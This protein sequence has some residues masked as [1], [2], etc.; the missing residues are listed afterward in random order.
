MFLEFNKYLFVTFVALTFLG[1]PYSIFNLYFTDVTGSAANNGID[2]SVY[3]S[4]VSNGSAIAVPPT[5]TTSLLSPTGS[6]IVTTSLKPLPTQTSV[7]LLEVRCGTSWAAANATCGSLCFTD[8]DCSPGL[9]CYK[10]VVGCVGRSL[11]PRDDSFSNLKSG[12]SNASLI[13]SSGLSSLTI[14]QIDAK[15]PWFWLPTSLTWLFSIICYLM[16]YK[17]CQLY[18]KHRRF[19]FTTSEFRDSVAHR[20][21]LITYIPHIKTSQELIEFVH[22]KD[23]SL[24]IQ[25]A[26]INRNSVR[27]GKLLVEHKD[28][29]KELERLLANIFEEEDSNGGNHEH[30]DSRSWTGSKE[31]HRLSS[32]LYGGI[33][34]EHNS[35]AGSET[36]DA[37]A[38]R[39][40]KDEYKF[41]SKTEKFKEDFWKQ[42][43]TKAKTG[44]ERLKEIEDT[45][46]EINQLEE[47]IE[48][49][50]LTPEHEFPS[51]ESGFLS[52]RTPQQAHRLIKTLRSHPKYIKKFGGLHIKFAPEFPDVYWANIGRSPHEIYA[53]RFF[54]LITTVAVTVGFIMLLGVLSTLQNLT[55]LFQ[56][57]PSAIE[58]LQNNPGWTNFLQTFVCPIPIALCNVL[59]PYI[60]QFITFLQGVKSGPGCDRS[61]IYKNYVFNMIQIF[62][63]ALIS[64]MI[65]NTA[66]A[67]SQIP[68]YVF[69]DPVLNQV[70]NGIESLVQNSYFYITMLASFY[71]GFGFEMLQ[72]VNL[73]I[74]FIRRK[75][76]KLTPRDEFELNGMQNMDFV[77]FYVTLV[78]AFTISLTFAIIAP[79]I[80]PF[81]MLF[82]GI[83]FVVMKYQLMVSIFLHGYSLYVSLMALALSKYVYEVERETYGSYFPKLFNVI[84]VSVLFFQLITL[85]VVFAGNVTA[86]YSSSEH[87]PLVKQ[88]MLLVPLP[89]L[90]GLL[91][92]WMR[93]YRIPQGL[94]CVDDIVQLNDPESSSFKTSSNPSST[95]TH[96]P[97]QYRVFNH[98]FVTPLPRV[99][100]APK[101]AERAKKYY[102]PRVRAAQDPNDPRVRAWALTLPSLEARK[103]DIVKRLLRSGNGGGAGYEELSNLSIEE[104]GG[105]GG[106][107]PEDEDVLA[108]QE[109][110]IEIERVRALGVVEAAVAKDD[111]DEDDDLD[112]PAAAAAITVEQ[113]V[114]EDVIVPEIIVEP[115]V[116]DLIRDEPAVT[117][118]QLV[119]EEENSTDGERSSEEPT[120]VVE[121]TVV[122]EQVEVVEDVRG[123]IASMDI[124]FSGEVQVEETLPELEVVDKDAEIV[125]I[126]AAP[127]VVE[128]PA[129]VDKRLSPLLIEVGAVGGISAVVAEV[130]DELP[131]SV[132][133]IDETA[134]VEVVGVLDERSVPDIPLTPTLEPGIDLPL[135]VEETLEPAIDES[136]HKQDNHTGH[137][138]IDPLAEKKEPD[139]IRVLVQDLMNVPEPKSPIIRADPEPLIPTPEPETRPSDEPE[140]YYVKATEPAII[141]TLEVDV[142]NPREHKE[143]TDHYVE[144][145]VFSQADI[146]KY[147]PTAAVRR[148]Y[149]DFDAFRK[150]L[151]YEF[152]S[153][154]FAPIPPKVSVLFN[155]SQDVI[156]SRRVAFATFL[157]S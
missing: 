110:V 86:T 4:I 128:D 118:E 53:R 16:L 138:L 106:V 58:W 115:P 92:L 150:D 29:T 17:L 139:A 57:N 83:T 73:V 81:S 6:P 2:S 69:T 102:T 19:Y 8:A 48:A 43:R 129:V 78:M 146:P 144:Y 14:T 52:L 71:A 105:M 64:G 70:V 13:V 75:F 103:K 123:Q 98:D 28:K 121:K 153:R 25:E 27:L 9:L 65:H 89:I 18:I 133:L 24:D 82:F 157:K 152:P 61:I 97:L 113:T 44:E 36:R 5:T 112:P 66:D 35:H 59:L 143:G 119:V 104:L 134:L 145:E 95:E 88:W 85:F 22:G 55:T 135:V 34:S 32:E 100:L 10:D 116:E 76:F 156:E 111:H 79:F 122:V 63:F 142:L 3:Q 154:E 15:S 67:A 87:V 49:I 84:S 125:V 99:L 45:K 91:W 72:G 107:M 147:S 137:E 56:N 50:R 21:L 74:S 30:V 101:Y 23:A 127:A 136:E 38:G 37:E 40:P 109:K 151:V 33:H 117:V 42:L 155:K 94:Y 120:D 90:T 31:D 20:T 39:S 26:T 47:A 77:Q 131:T 148:R 130:V 54:A 141:S 60:L 124:R 68:T 108:I 1:V 96:T 7:A 62:L 46:N 132:D 41:Q 149:R 51:N 80:L 11:S 114:S 140:I 93:V 126:R 12:S